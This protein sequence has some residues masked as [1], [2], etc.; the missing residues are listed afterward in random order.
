MKENEITKLIIGA[1]IEVHRQLDP[2]LLES[3]YQEC[4][5]FEL[6]QRGLFVTKEIPMPIILQRS[7][8]KSWISNRYRCRR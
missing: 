8:V 5:L 1:A 4:L 6:R 7:K 2:G 3:A